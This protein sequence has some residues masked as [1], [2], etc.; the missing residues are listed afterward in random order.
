MLTYLPPRPPASDAVAARAATL[1]R[2][3]E[4]AH[5]ALAEREPDPIEDA[6]RAQSRCFRQ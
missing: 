1:L 4:E 2:F 6:E 5:A 3:A